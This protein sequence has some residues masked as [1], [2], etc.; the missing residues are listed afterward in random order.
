MSVSVSGVCM[1]QFLCVRVRVSMYPCVCVSVFQ[2]VR[3]SVCPCVHMS[4]CLCV[5]E[6]VSVS[7]CPNVMDAYRGS[8]GMAPLNPNLPS[9]PNAV[10]RTIHAPV[11]LSPG[12][13]E[14][15]VGRA[16]EPSER[17]Y[18]RDVKAGLSRPVT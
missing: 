10:Y 13:S 4:V 3:M 6:Y 11:A 18:V 12:A 16:P 15:Q 5:R 8:R 14:Q 17:S 2:C 7:V 9:K 1:S